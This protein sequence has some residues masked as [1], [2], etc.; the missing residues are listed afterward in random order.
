M[1]VVF[2]DFDCVESECVECG[3]IRYWEDSPFGFADY[4]KD[5]SGK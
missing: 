2:D 5:N 4:W 3:S 1:E